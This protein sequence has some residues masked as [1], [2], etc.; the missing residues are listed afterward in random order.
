MPFL[1]AVFVFLAGCASTPGAT[2]ADVGSATAS[3][4]GAPYEDVVRSW[5]APARSTKLP[6]GRDA[7]TWVSETVVS[8]GSFWPSIGIIGGS[9]GVGIGTGVTMGPGYGDLQRC[10]RTLFFDKGR[11]TDQTWQGPPDFCSSFRR[12]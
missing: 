10:E 6:D 3:W 12:G 11:V 7:H 8:R 2:D 4:H 1:L 5:G 9:G